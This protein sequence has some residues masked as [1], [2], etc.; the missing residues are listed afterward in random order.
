MAEFEEWS[1]DL[2]AAAERVRGRLVLDDGGDVDASIIRDWLVMSADSAESDERK[3]RRD[4]ADNPQ[5]TDREY[6]GQPA[7]AGDGVYHAAR[8]ARLI[9]G[10]PPF[11]APGE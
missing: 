8:L 11:P 7:Y 2:R 5:L 10:K 6:G 3:Y 1:R 4:Y 9:L